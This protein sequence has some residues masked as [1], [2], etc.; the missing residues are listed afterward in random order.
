MSAAK[1]HI[2]DPLEREITTYNRLLP[3]LLADEGKYVLIIGDDKIDV[4]FAYEDA[5]KAG[6][7]H[8]GLK[9]FLVR[10]ISGTESVMYFTRDI[11]ASCLTTATQ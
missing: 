10:K 1:R 3:S 4:F 2:P 9:P 7:Q 5:L 8:A 6:Y 11:A